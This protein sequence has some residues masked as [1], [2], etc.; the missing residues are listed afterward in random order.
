THTGDPNLRGVF[1]CHD[2][3][4]SVRRRQFDAVIGVGGQGAE[5]KEY[6]IDRKLTWIGIGP[7]PE[8]VPD[9]WNYAGPLL[10]FDHFIKFDSTGELLED[11]APRLAKRLYGKKPRTIM[12]FSPA[13]WKEVECILE[14]AENSPPSTAMKSGNHK[15]QPKCCAKHRWC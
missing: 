9:S 13:E 11:I 4:G 14:R 7:H 5:A 3:M 10:T 2:C 12:T 6:E 1:G 8:E 15:I